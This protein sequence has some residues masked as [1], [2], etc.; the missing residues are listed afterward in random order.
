MNHSVFSAADIAPPPPGRLFLAASRAVA[1]LPGLPELLGAPVV[2]WRRGLAVPDGAR[3]LAWGRKP[4]ARR[5]QALAAALGLP[6]LRLEDGFLRSVGLGADEPPLSVVWDD[7]GIYYDATG[8]SRLE[9]LIAAGADAA[10]LDR[11][12]R[13][14]AAWK[15]G[16]VSKYNLAREDGSDLPEGFVLVAD[17][18]L[19]DASV[20]CGAADAASFARM[21]EAALDEH[22]GCPVVLKV[23]PEVALGRKRGHFDLDA[24]RRLDRVTVL[25]RA[26]HPAGLL[27]RAAAVYAVTSQF[28]FEALVWGCP[29]RTFGMPF[30]AGWGLT[31]DALPRPARRS[32]VSLDALVHAA[33]LAY[34][35]YRDPE[36]G[37]ACPAERVLAWLALQRRMRERFAPRV[38]G[39]RFSAWKR[40]I[41]RRFFQGSQVSFV[42]R[43]TDAPAGATLAVWGRRDPGPTSARVVRLEDGFLRSVGLGVDLVQP[44][45]W[46]MDAVGM[47]YDATAAS[48]LERLLEEGGV[49]AGLLSR[50]AA[51]RQRIVAEGITKYNVGQGNWTR[52]AGVSR[53]VLVPGQVEA[54]ASITWGAPRLRTNMDLLR[55]VREKEKDAYVVYKPHPDVVAQ[56]C[57]PGSGEERAESL[58]DAVVLHTPMHVLLEHVDAV[59]VLTSLAGFEALLRGREVWCHGLPFYAGWGLTRDALS[60]P[61][62]TRRLTLDELVAG[63]LIAYPAYVHPGT[64]RFTTA[65]GAL[66][67]LAAWREAGPSLPWWRKRLR[68]VLAVLKRS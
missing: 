66:S 13:L 50:A 48:A 56:I 47:Y 26:L 27:S 45:S 68:R 28:G 23:H 12:R 24:L 61:R 10:S 9:R 53:V 4:S 16:R 7:T 57:R 1:D 6:V 60:T 41:V 18:T 30:Y 40:P 64:G 3:V 46:V 67:F 62:R 2:R 33:L 34:P 39:W 49:D 55:A 5:A 51:L 17:Q 32:P 15:A 14:G 42:R 65:E 35:R 20:A 19:G 59:H 58:C 52:P 31:T 54:D 22:P 11:A 29:V 43:A 37:R 8:P 63:A 25:G 44:V 21:L 36:T 38:Y